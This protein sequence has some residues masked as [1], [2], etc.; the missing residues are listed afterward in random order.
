MFDVVGIG[1]CALDYLG[2]VDAHPDVN[3]KTELSDFKVEGG[4]PT[5]TAMVTLCRFNVPA[6]FIGKVG[7]DPFG[8]D[9]KQ[10]LIAEGV[11]VSAMVTEP[12]KASQYAFISV[13]RDT[14]QRNIFFTRGTV[15]PLSFEEVQKS[16]IDSCKILH[17]DGLMIDTSIKAAKYAKSL[18]KK[19]SLDAGTLREGMLELCKY[20][21]YLVTSEKF[22]RSYIG[23]DDFEG[24]LK[25]LKELGP[26]IVCVTLGEKGSIAL[27]DGQI[28]RQAAYRVPVVD[29][30]G[31][32]DVYH[33]GFLF[34][35]LKGYNIKK[36]MRF[37][38]FVAALKCR[39]LGGRSGIPQTEECEL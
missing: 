27:K 16:L 17:L 23:S 5:A 31:A 8:D 30:T 21:D 10:G 19:V 34:G 25:R 12:G 3:E 4:G 7:D 28:H 2:I 32:G 24:A 36:T 9:I 26:E 35:L 22:A 37:A 20:T 6:T 33:G 14:G 39:E 29:T 15:T 13:E 18:G 11:D 38:S 1:Q